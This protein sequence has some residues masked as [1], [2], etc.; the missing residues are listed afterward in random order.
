MSY[1]PCA[2]TNSSTLATNL[3]ISVAA[4]A[5]VNPVYLPWQWLNLRPSGPICI[6]LRYC[7]ISHSLILLAL[8]KQNYVVP[9]E[10]KIVR[11]QFTKS[12]KRNFRNQ[13][14]PIP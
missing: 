7:S 12:F 10:Q 4:E 9:V 3:T 5:R 1:L 11:N 8:Q 13:T 2:D 6:R 14:K